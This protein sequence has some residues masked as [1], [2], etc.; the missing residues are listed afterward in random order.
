MSQ[1]PDYLVNGRKVTLLPAKT[2]TTALTGDT[3]GYGA[4][5]GVDLGYGLQYVGF[6][7]VF[8][9]G[10]GGTTAK[11]WI[12]TSFDNGTTWFD[13]ANMAFT[14]ATLT[15]VGAVSS[16]IVAAAPATPTD[17]A[18]AD[19]TIN[20]GLLGNKIRVKLTTTGTYAGG[21]TLKIDIIAKG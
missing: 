6:Q 8:T 20:N 15:K 13:V 4:A 7:G 14:T 16:R 10:S 3:S 21:T 18:L 2:I 9:Y 19:N 1:W 12:Q 17:A 5:A 11:A